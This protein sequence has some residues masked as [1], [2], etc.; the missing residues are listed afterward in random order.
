MSG[1]TKL[2]P[3]IVQSSIWNEPPEVRV[4]WITMIATKDESGYV[5]GDA[6]TLS[7][8]ANVDH[9]TVERALEL[10]QSPDP[11]SHTPDNE[12]R[13]I[14]AAPGGWIVLNHGIYRA[15]EE[16]IREQ[17]RKRVQKYRENKKKG[18]DVTQ[19][20]VTETLP[21]VSVSAS[22]SVSAHKGES[23]GGAKFD[24]FWAEYP[25]KTNKGPARKAWGKMRCNSKFDEIMA[26]VASHKASGIWNDPAYTPHPSTW[27]NGERWGDDPT[28]A[29]SNGTTTQTDPTADPEWHYDLWLGIARK[30]PGRRTEAMGQIESA[31]GAD[32][33]AEFTRRMES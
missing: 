8:M 26:S 17:T 21:S 6:K 9:E 25:R 10:F 7:R 32:A 29:Q 11:S 5:R 3:E 15:K 14:M 19:G 4:V 33:V 16:V 13:R 23:E 2:V 24:A 18:D 27:L 20:N 22:A 1:F 12:G 28:T 30:Q 31:L